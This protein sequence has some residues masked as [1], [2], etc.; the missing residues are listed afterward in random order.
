MR[1]HANKSMQSGFTL[2]ELMIVVAVVAI[3]AAVAIPS[4]QESSNKSKRRDA[5]AALSGLASAME[6][7]YTQN[8]TYL[9]AADTNNRPIATLYPHE[10]PLDGNTKYYDLR[11]TNLAATTY[12]L[13]AI[14]KGGMASDRCGTMTMTHTGATSQ[15]AGETNCW[16]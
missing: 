2:I 8:N 16:P 10:A 13:S 3:I 9:N 5:Q 11:I 14:P 1:F 7:Y 4:Y 15:K 6:R 12:T